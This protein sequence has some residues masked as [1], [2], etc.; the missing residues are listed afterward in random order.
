MAGL[1]GIKALGFYYPTGEHSGNGIH[2][3][4]SIMAIRSSGNMNRFE[5]NDVGLLDRVGLPV[6]DPLNNETF[7]FCESK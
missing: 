4:L 6:V 3:F 5:I 7:G 2:Y 1:P